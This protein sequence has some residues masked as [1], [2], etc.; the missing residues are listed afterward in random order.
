MSIATKIGDEEVDADC[1]DVLKGALQKSL[2]VRKSATQLLAMDWFTNFLDQ[3]DQKV[4]NK[5][6]N[7]TQ[8]LDLMLKNQSSRGIGMGM[9]MQQANSGPAA[10]QV[11]GGQ[12]GASSSAQYSQ[13]QNQQH[14][15]SS[16]TGLSHVNV[17][18]GIATPRG[19]EDQEDQEE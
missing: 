8:K 19:G 6:R 3:E 1:I 15:S 7:E 10:E 16:P 5:I 14:Q 2:R 12:A 18:Q 4:Q 13:S 9:A 11:Q 17:A